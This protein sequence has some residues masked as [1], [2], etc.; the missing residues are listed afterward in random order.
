MQGLIRVLLECVGERRFR[1]RQAVVAWWCLCSGK[2][3]GLV[4]WHS[5]AV[6]RGRPV[7][8]AWQPANRDGSKGTHE[9]KN[10]VARLCSA[11]ARRGGDYGARVW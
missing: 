10:F 7:T 11:L 2:G 8:A 5:L 9:G 1:E 4:A 3:S 6:H